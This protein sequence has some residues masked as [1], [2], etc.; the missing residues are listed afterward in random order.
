MDPRIAAYQNILLEM[1]NY[2]RTLQSEI[3]EKQLDKLDIKSKESWNN[4]L[5]E[6]IQKLLAKDNLIN[7]SSNHSILV[8][9]IKALKM[10]DNLSINR[11]GIIVFKE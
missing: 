1:A 6:L 2:Q 3:A 9:K 7:I 4:Y 8:R 10:E 5:I 11:N